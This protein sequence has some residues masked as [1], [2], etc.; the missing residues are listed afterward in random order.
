VEKI[1]TPLW[2]PSMS[3]YDHNNNNNNNREQPKVYSLKFAVKR[4]QLE[5]YSLDLDMIW[6]EFGK[7]LFLNSNE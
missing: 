1:I 4:Q 7:M 3:D 2:Q 5:T 6:K